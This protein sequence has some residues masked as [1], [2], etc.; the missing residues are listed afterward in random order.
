MINRRKFIKYTI[1]GSLSIKLNPNEFV[2]ILDIK[3]KTNEE[4]WNRIKRLHLK[5]LNRNKI[6]NKK[7]IDYWTNLTLLKAKKKLD[8][9]EF[10]IL[11]KDNFFI[12]AWKEDYQ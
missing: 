2:S 10:K 3:P 1:I 9:N 5:A 4:K 11:M 8:E 7:L 6:A 12:P